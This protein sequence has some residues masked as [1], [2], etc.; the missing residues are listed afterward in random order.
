MEKPHI[1][2]LNTEDSEEVR[3][4]LNPDAAKRDKDN[5]IK[6]TKNKKEKKS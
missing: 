5:G 2:F 3:K 4:K 6:K 1:T